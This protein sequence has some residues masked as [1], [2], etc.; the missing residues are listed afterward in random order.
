MS[1][2]STTRR[3]NGMDS[4]FYYMD[5]AHAGMHGAF[6]QIYAAVPGEGPAT[7]YQRL[8]RHIEASLDKAS[9]FRRHIV[10][11]ALDLDH[12]RWVD[13]G[14][15]DL[16]HHVRHLALPQPGTRQQLCEIYSQIFAQP[17]DLTRPLWEIHV[18]DELNAVEGVPPGS[19]AL[20]VKFHHAGVDGVSATEISSALHDTQPIRRPYPPGSPLSLPLMSQNEGRTPVPMA[21]RHSALLSAR[22]GRA[23]A[24]QLPIAGRAVLQR[25]RNRRKPATSKRSSSGRAA[26]PRTLINV[27]LSTGRSY[28][29]LPMDLQE[30]KTI[31][32]AVPGATVNDVF[33]AVAGGALRQLLLERDGLPSTSLIAAVPVNIRLENEKGQA[34]NQFTIMQVALRTDEADG[35]ARLRSIVE[36]SVAAKARMGGRSGGRKSVNWLNLIPAPLLSIASEALRRSRLTARLAP[37]FNLVVTNVPGPRETLYLDGARLLDINGAPP[38]VDGLG[39]V[40]AASSYEGALRVGVVACRNVLPQAEPMRQYLL[41]ALAELR[42]GLSAKPARTSARPKT[43]VKARTSRSRTKNSEEA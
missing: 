4:M 33:L 24:A 12:A 1:A 19:F 20:V 30:I 37:L 23:L 31:R 3:F 10:R 17:M 21:L 14:E 38:V 42:D 43:S 18:I 26:A 7:R 25:L 6:L 41:E 15:V 9:T 2:A 39:M 11:T 16:A 13:G 32:E 28:T 8:V 36:A 27:P 40:I 34:G 35:I 29:F 5:A 22:L